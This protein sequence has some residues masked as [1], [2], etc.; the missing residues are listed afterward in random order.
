MPESLPVA[1]REKKRLKAEQK[2]AL[3]NEPTPQ[4]EQ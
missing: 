3:E 4:G 2:K 1:G